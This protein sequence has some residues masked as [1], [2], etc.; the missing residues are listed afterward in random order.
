MDRPGFS[1]VK[2]YDR[3]LEDLLRDGSVFGSR[4]LL[5]QQE[6]GEWIALARGNGGA[7]KGRRGR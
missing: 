2:V 5:T 7:V 6:A 3:I 1:E 4:R